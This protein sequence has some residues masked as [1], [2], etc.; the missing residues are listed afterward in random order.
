[1]LSELNTSLHV[2]AKDDV[3]QKDIDQFHSGENN[4]KR[5]QQWLLQVPGNPL[6]QAGIEPALGFAVD[7]R[8]IK[9]VAI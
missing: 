6:P 7:P 9:T 3:Y 4:E 1:M 2:P 8:R 5:H